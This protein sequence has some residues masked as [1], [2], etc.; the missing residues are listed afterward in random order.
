MPDHAL[1][2]RSVLLVEDE[3]LIADTLALAFEDAGAEVIG[4]AP[5]VAQALALIEGG[6]RI[7]VAVLDAN[8][9]GERAWPIAETLAQRAIPFLLVT[10]YDASSLPPQ[11][12]HAVRLEKPVNFDEVVRTAADLT[13]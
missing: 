13:R 8:L 4:P 2:G 9:G 1:A 10:G 12:Q 7:D 3:Y 5:T 11:F 6:S